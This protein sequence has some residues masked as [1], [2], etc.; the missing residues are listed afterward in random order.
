MEQIQAF[1]KT[2]LAVLKF[3]FFSITMGQALVA[4]GFIFAGFL[5]RKILERAFEGLEA[6][7]K[8]TT[9]IYDDLLLEIVRKPLAAAC[10]PLGIYLAVRTLP[11]PKTPV[12]AAAVLSAAFKTV[13]IVFIV[14]LGLRFIDGTCKVW[15]GYAKRTESSIDDILVPIVSKSLKSFLVIV[16]GILA[17]QNMGY[18]VSGLLAGFGLGGMAVALAAK[19]SLSNIFGS[20]VILL[21]RPFKVGDWIEMNGLEGTIEEIG[22]RTTR[23]RTFANSL[24]TVPNAKWTTSAINNWSR[25]QKRRI[26]T[27][28]GVT[29]DTTPEQIEALVE[30]IRGL[31][32][33]DEGLR[34]E[35]FLVNFDGFGPSSLDIFI[36]CFTKTT[37]WGE[38]L[39]VKERF[40]LNI[41]REVHKAGLQFA[42]PTQ[43]VHLAGS[44]EAVKA[45]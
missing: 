24:I 44:G 31:I 18:S 19:E 40:F 35:F 45:G 20:I 21:D 36:Y 9:T 29:Y 5:L 38:Y 16:G 26:S 34:D 32:R 10:V 39:T 33:S 22:L 12:D 42:F 1:E 4:L 15:A 43:T 2:I 14:W 41:A 30:T 28:I 11:L 6:A 27:K 17:L 23:V 8:R 3:E 7:V 37:Q 25:M 13:S